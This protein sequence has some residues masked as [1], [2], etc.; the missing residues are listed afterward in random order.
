MGKNGSYLPTMDGAKMSS[1]ELYGRW[2]SILQRCYNANCKDFKWYGARGISVHLPWHSAK[3]FIDEIGPR[4]SAGMEIDR[5][6]NNGNYEPGNVRWVTH[7]A[8]SR[9]RSTS[10]YVEYGGESRLLM[11]VAAE[12]G[13]RHK[14]LY[15]RLRLG[16]ADPFNPADQRLRK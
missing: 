11:D 4:P 5:I 6:D 8:N 12:L 7:K 1:H 13:L 10:V 3:V 14:T 16:V 9:N 2:V 15:E